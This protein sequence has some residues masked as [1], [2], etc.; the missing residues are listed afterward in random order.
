[1]DDTVTGSLDVLNS[2]QLSS[3]LEGM[4]AVSKDILKN[5]E[6][7]AVLL[8]GVVNE[9]QDYTTTEIM[10]FIESD[11][12]V[13]DADVST[14]RTNTRIQGENIEFVQLNE[15]TSN[16]DI[17]FISKNPILSS[18]V[19]VNL[20][21]DVEPQKDYRPGY[22]IEKR[23]MYYLSRSLCSQ[24]SVITQKTD[25]N[26]LAKCYSIWICRDNIPLEEQYSISYYEMENSRNI[27]NCL[28]RKE[29][30][31]L[32]SLVII[33]LGNPECVSKEGK[34]GILEFLSAIFYP[35]KKDFLDTVQKYIDFSQNEEL[36]KEVSHM[37]GLGMS[38]LQEGI[39]EGI[40]KGIQEGME[41]GMQEGRANQLILNVSNLRK[42]M[43]LSLED[44]CRVLKIE[45]VEYDRA[46]ELVQ[47]KGS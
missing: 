39:Q 42:T 27:G 34:E 31:D 13:S 32:L 22:P 28:T 8:K 6:V 14:G 12:I 25:Y 15:K 41:K 43:N 9:Y 35:H 33:R 30:Y 3:D 11:S 16:F 46:R 5:K 19:Q 24:L 44:A 36:W 40:E 20:H 2:L 47:K 1:M 45:P 37:S 23:G 4:D 10:E 29:D 38:I 26:A 18:E 21:I 17:R 7:L